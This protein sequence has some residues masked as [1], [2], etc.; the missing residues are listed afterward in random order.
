MLIASNSKV[1][2]PGIALNKVAQQAVKEAVEEAKEEAERGLAKAEE[3]AKDESTSASSTPPVL[4]TEAQST[5]TPSEDLIDEL[6]STN[7]LSKAEEIYKRLQDSEANATNKIKNE[8]MYFYVSFKLGNSEALSKIQE[9]T[10]KE[11]AAPFAHRG[12]ALCYEFATE[13]DKALCE[14]ELAAEKTDDEERKVFDITKAAECLF[15]M[16]NQQEAYNK[17][18]N[19]IRQTHKPKDISQLYVGLASLYNRANNHELRAFALEKALEFD[20]SN[21]EILFDAAYSYG[22]TNLHGISILHYKANL[23]FDPQDSASL[24]NGGVEYNRLQ[25]KI[26]AT[27]FFKSASDLNHTLA[28]SNL[29]NSYMNAGFADEARTVLNKAKQQESVHKNIGSSIS[30]LAEKEEAESKKEQEIV[31]SAI[32]QQR[33]FRSYSEAYFVPKFSHSF[34]GTWLFSDG[35]EAIISQTDDTMTGEWVRESK[36]SKIEGKITNQTAK[37]TWHKMTYYAGDK[38][39]IYSKDSEGYAYLAEDGEKLEIMTLNNN[40]HTSTTLTRKDGDDAQ[41]DEA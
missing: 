41:P 17:T 22:Q 24:N 31:S 28:A 14:F 37:V 38:E 36:K 32:Q 13:L 18:L 16:D 40:V 30:S 20:P 33:F 35:V 25:M 9:L 3:R 5:L 15:L 23:R 6:L 29:A 27:R 1:G 19:H 2:L 8:I 12:L 26:N 34:A 10:K 11:E 39:L 4:D 21:L 7:D